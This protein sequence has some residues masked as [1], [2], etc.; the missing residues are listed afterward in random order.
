VPQIAW[1]AHSRPTSPP[2][3]LGIKG[4]R[5]LSIL[6]TLTLFYVLVVLPL[7]PDDGAGR[8]ENI[9]FWPI[10][11]AITLLLVV[12]NWSRVDRNFLRSLPISSLAAY[13]LFAAASVAWAYSRELAFSRM[14]SHVFLFIIVLLPYSL[15]IRKSFSFGTIHACY[16]IA[17]LVSALYVLTVPASPIGHAGY[18]TH[19]QGLGLLCAVAIILASHEVLFGSWLRRG[20]SVVSFSL[21]TWLIIE[22]QS[23]SA[24]ALSLIA[25]IFGFVLILIN[26]L[27]KVTPAI[28]VGAV[29]V[30]SV[31]VKNPVERAGYWLYGDSTL[32]GRTAIWAFI[33]QQ[34]SRAPWIGWGFHSYYMVPNTPHNHAVGYIKDMNSSHSGYLELKLETGRIG[35]WIFLIFIFSTLHR[36][37]AVMRRNPRSAWFYTST[38]LFALMLN[39]LDSLWLG[40]NHLWVLYLLVVAEAVRYSIASPSE[41]AS[42]QARPRSGRVTKFAEFFSTRRFAPRHS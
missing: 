23:K 29:M 4:G 21:A 17:L 32:T 33:E 35:Y 3:A 11:A 6:P 27:P 12:N 8:I 30:V 36:L 24:L 2:P 7:I 25:M 13:L 22:S 28:I 1:R 16:V 10:T 19:K 34:I 18:F 40:L 20:L 39:L 15:P 41:S 42:K 9:L 31:F 26:K 14:A 5:V 37:D 38:V